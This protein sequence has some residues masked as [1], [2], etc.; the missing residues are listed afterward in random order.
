M[1]SFIERKGGGHRPRHSSPCRSRF[2]SFFF[3]K[4]KKRQRSTQLIDPIDGLL[5]RVG[6]FSLILFLLFFRFLLLPLYLSPFYVGG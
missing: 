4:K 1:M 6:R 3:K 2:L 5:L